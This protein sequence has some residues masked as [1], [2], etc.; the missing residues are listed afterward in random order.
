MARNQADNSR[1]TARGLSAIVRRVLHF[2]STSPFFTT[3]DDPD[4]ARRIVAYQFA[5]DLSASQM[6]AAL[7]AAGPWRWEARD[8]VW[9]KDELSATVSDHAIVRIY[10]EGATCNLSFFFK[11]RGDRVQ[12]EWEQIHRIIQETVFPALS[13]TRVRLDSPNDPPAGW[14]RTPAKDLSDPQSE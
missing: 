11:S 7:N 6:S 13:A 3:S 8:T 9:Y 10:N 5:C 12:Q 1:L 4:S 14:W 2:F